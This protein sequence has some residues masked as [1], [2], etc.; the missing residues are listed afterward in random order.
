M[1]T[2]LKGFGNF[3]ALFLF[4]YVVK[5][6]KL[7]LQGSTSE[8]VSVSELKAY[9]Q[10][11]G[12]ANDSTLTAFITAARAM[13]ENRLGVSLIEKDAIAWMILGAKCEQIP[14]YPISSITSVEYSDDG[15]ETWETLTEFDDY[16]IIGTDRQEIETT[17]PGLHK[18]TYET[19]AGDYSDLIEAVKVQAGYMWTHRDAA[20]VK[21]ISPIV[22]IMIQPYILSY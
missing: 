16:I 7:T 9:L 8:P 12:T 6:L 5:D 18:I 17:V 21:G 14:I 22:E 2:K 20:N 10:L 1:A 15:G 11:E 4:T 3:P 19:G 13:I